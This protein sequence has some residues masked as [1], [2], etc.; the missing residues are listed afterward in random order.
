[1]K[2]TAVGPN[3]VSATGNVSVLQTVKLLGL[4]ASVA[5]ATTST[6]SGNL[7][8]PNVTT[9]TISTPASPHLGVA[10]AQNLQPSSGGSSGLGKK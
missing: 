6:G 2:L 7:A 4:P 1:M 8:Q 10:M 5:S 9:V 3:Q